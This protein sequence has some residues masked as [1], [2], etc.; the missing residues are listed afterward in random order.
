MAEGN[1]P[2]PIPVPYDSPIPVVNAQDYDTLPTG[3]VYNTGV[4]ANCPTTNGYIVVITIGFGNSGQDKCAQF[5][6][7]LFT[8]STSKLYFRAK[9][10]NT[11]RD[12]T[13]L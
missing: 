4:G 7:D 2:R 11:W 12:W 9:T 5:G 3:I 13:Q 8:Q 10:N 1:S 6:I